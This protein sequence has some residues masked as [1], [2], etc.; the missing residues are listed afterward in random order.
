M[1]NYKE[2]IQDFL[3]SDTKEAKIT[4]VVLSVLALA[5]L[6]VLVAG[7]GAMGNAVQV[8]KMFNG[9][10]KYSKSQI[11]SAFQNLHR[12]KLIEYIN[13]KNGKSI[14]RITQKGQTRLR[15]FSIET[16]K[17]KTPKAWDGKWRLVM[18]DL[19]LRFKKGRNALRY[20]LMELGFLQFQKSA[21]IYPY[22]CEEEIVFIAD[23]FCMTKYI[24]ILSVDSM[25]NEAKFKK[26]FNLKKRS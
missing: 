10:K 20:H 3:N 1:K 13:D 21:W 2:R 9:S 23:F 7:A 25:L 18:Y 19:P 24:E 22:P 15:A 14:V 11:K 4:L 8:F 26:Y 12:Q 6:P 16:M 17:I 5:T